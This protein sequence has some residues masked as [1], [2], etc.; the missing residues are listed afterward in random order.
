ML[1]TITLILPIFLK[2]N[3]INILLV[4]EIKNMNND[5]NFWFIITPPLLS[6]HK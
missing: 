1:V 2:I 3:L 5:G 6:S 4:N